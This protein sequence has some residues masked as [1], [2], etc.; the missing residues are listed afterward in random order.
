MEVV[1]LE[2]LRHSD[3]LKTET[4]ALFYLKLVEVEVEGLQMMEHK[5]VQVQFQV[6]QAELGVV[7]VE[8]EVI[9]Q[10]V[11]GLH[12]VVLG[13]MVVVLELEMDHEVVEV[14]GAYSGFLEVAVL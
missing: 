12:C 3:H 10:V 14:E 6:V 1:G 7:E 13:V 9:Q 4:W 5:V 8:L 2:V 11:E